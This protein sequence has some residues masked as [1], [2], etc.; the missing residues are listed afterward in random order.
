MSSSAS[1]FGTPS[2]TGFGAESTKSLASFSPNDVAARTALI[3]ETL[4]SPAAVK[5]TSNSV[6]SSPPA[7][8]AP[9]AAAPEGATARYAGKWAI[10]MAEVFSKNR[11]IEFYRV[12]GTIWPNNWNEHPNVKQITY[13]EFDEHLINR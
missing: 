8:A 12:G 1:F 4:L 10:Q 5:I 6:F 13:E 3:T 11:H 7:D 2:L 9:G